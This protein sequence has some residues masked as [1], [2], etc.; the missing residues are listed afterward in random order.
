MAT[1]QNQVKDGA[2]TA[3]QSKMVRAALCM[4]PFLHFGFLLFDLSSLWIQKN[5]TIKKLMTH[6]PA[7]NL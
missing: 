7:Q 3:R 2:R 6:F 5:Q 1:F 4:S